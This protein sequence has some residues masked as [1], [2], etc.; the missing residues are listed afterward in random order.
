MKLIIDIADNKAA[1]FMEMIKNYSDVKA[2]PLSAPDAQL[3]DEIKEIKKAFKNV[4]RI[5]A[6]KLKGRPAEE[7]LNE[8]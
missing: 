2:K 4:E 8:I 6:G 7:F 5:K 3:F 1:G